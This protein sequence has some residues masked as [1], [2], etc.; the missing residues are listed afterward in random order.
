MNFFRLRLVTVITE[1]ALESR[2]VKDIERLGAQGYTITPARGKGARGTRDASWDSSA[3]IRIEIICD[4]DV[5]QEIASYFK[6]N[7]YDN[8]AMVLYMHDVDVL[9]S[10]KF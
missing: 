10:N 7:Y 2:L 5:E 6:E 1:S 8:Y 9:R 4:A 3:N